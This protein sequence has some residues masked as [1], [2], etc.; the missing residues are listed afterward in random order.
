MNPAKSASDITIA[1]A[2]PAC[3]GNGGIGP[4]VPIRDRQGNARFQPCSSCDGT[5]WKQMPWEKI[6]PELAHQV[7]ERL[8]PIPP[9]PEEEK[10]DQDS[11]DHIRT[12]LQGKRIEQVEFPG[13]NPREIRLLSKGWWISIH[14]Q[15]K[16]GRFRQLYALPY[17]AKTGDETEDLKTEDLKTQD[18]RQAPLT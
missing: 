4:R 12:M 9:D 6:T 8:L 2:C 14:A 5:G 11:M 10:N 7:R 16:G 17:M 13:G 1:I 18:T 15:F 3:L